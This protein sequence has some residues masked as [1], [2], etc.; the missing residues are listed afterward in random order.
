MISKESQLRT[1]IRQTCIDYANLSD[2]SSDGRGRYL[3]LANLLQ[4]G[5][6]CSIQAAF[7]MARNYNK[8]YVR[9]TEGRYADLLALISPL[10]NCGCECK[11]RDREANCTCDQK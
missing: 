10:L 6:Q 9:N 7:N 2:M 3:T 11:C 8:R 5:D 4:Y 1:S